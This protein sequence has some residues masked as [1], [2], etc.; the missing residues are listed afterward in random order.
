[1]LFVERKAVGAH[2][3]AILYAVA[4]PKEMKKY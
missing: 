1:M 3:L 2:D 4:D